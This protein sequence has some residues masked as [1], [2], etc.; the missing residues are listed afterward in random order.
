MSG[1]RIF[2][3]SIIEVCSFMLL[4][5][6]LNKQ[7]GK[8]LEKSAVIVILTA[9]V[10][11]AANYLYASVEFFIN[12]GF[13]FLMI[14][15]VFKKSLKSLLMEFSL[16]LA[17]CG[18]MQ[19]A[20]I[21][22]LRL[23]SPSFM[24]EDIFL[25]SLFANIISLLFSCFLYKFINSESLITLYREESPKIN[26][27]SVNLL[28]YSIIVKW[29]W[30]FKRQM[31]LE[32]IILFFAIPV[33][34]IIGNMIF[35]VYHLKNRELKKSLEEYKKYSSVISELLEDVRQRQH[36]FKNHLNTV[37]GLIQISDERT[38]KE[39]VRR[40]MNS[41]NVSLENIDK[42]LQINN[43][44]VTAIIYNKINEA[45][46]YQIQFRYTIQYDSVKLPFKDYELSEILNNLLD[47]AFEAVINEERN[48]KRVFLNI[49]YVE[50]G[51]ILEIGNTGQKVKLNEIG[52][53]FNMGYTTKL[54]GNRGYGLHN[55]KKIVE[56]YGGR[57]Q[58]SFENNYTIFRVMLS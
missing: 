22:T 7:Y 16:L 48:Q 44:V 21:F 37:Y 49:G 4:W 34:Y 25:N 26:F 54:G 18:I 14:K 40:Y 41:V 1:F 42:V 15:L 47:N 51:C 32:E 33:V 29:I 17:V 56:S 58:L 35:L 45:S 36:D 50:E 8:R 23:V 2:V 53:I 46:K 11:V 57:I 28:L 10:V 52:R 43:K 39:T 24:A 19:L 31:F 6:V 3:L 30:N 9:F 27:F 12:Y 13:L 55:V 5:N 20:V 38:L